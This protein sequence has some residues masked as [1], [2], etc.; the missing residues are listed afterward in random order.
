MNNYFTINCIK[1]NKKLV[2]EFEVQSLLWNEYIDAIKTHCEE[3]SHYVFTILGLYKIANSIE[4]S[5]ILTQDNYIKTLNKQFRNKEQ[6][7]NILSFPLE[8]IQANNFEQLKIHGDFVFLGDIIFSFETIYKESKEKNISFINHFMHLLVHGILHCCGYDHEEPNE[9][10]I[11]EAKEVE[12]LAHFKIRS[13][14]SVDT[15]N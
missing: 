10:A 15:D 3:I 13:P 11:M 9:A 4:Y 8:E 12:I 1:E 7:T 6:P 5:I 14:Y 2:I